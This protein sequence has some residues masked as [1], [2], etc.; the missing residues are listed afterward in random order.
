MRIRDLSL[1][2]ACFIPLFGSA[3]LSE[4][5]STSLCLRLR[6]G[7]LDKFGH[8]LSLRGEGRGREPMPSCA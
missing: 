6:G 3:R 7:A 4:H 8:K 5:A 2:L 1:L